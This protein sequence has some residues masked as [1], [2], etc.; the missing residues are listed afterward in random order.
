MRKGLWALIGALVAIALLTPTAAAQSIEDKR[1]E[2]ERIADRLEALNLHYA[3][4]EED[5]AEASVRL[6]Q[7]TNEVAIAQ[8]Q[9]ADTE[10]ALGAVASEMNQVAIDSYVRAR[11]GDDVVQVL[12][13]GADTAAPL[14]SAYEQALLGGQ[15]VQGDALDS[16]LEDAATARL[17]LQVKQGEQAS[18]Q[19]DL[20]AKQVEVQAAAAETKALLDQVQGELAVLV[21][22]ERQRRAA[23]ERAAAQAA[24]E[25]AAAAQRAREN[26]P[27]APQAGGGSGGSSESGSGGEAESSAPPPPRR[28]PPPPSGG[29]A[30]AVES[31]LSQIGVPYRWATADP[32]V[33]FD[34][35]GLVS[36]AWGRNGRQ[37]PR[38][39][40]AMFNALPRVDLADIQP[41]DLVFFG[42]PVH[43]VGM[44][45]GD[46]TMVDAPQSGEVVRTASIYRRDMA[47][48]GRP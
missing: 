11:P 40:R 14:R 22:Q 9:V 21:E 25:R 39:S 3:V 35:S 8:Q 12:V 4:L 20:A 37:L 16:R 27:Q 1:R 5:Y 31:A 36:W 41:G 47:G 19:A 48:I 44:Y 43:H 24:A 10:A 6:E 26:A 17:Q 28:E 32:D 2:A 42:S 33:G 13:S 23:A 29:A 15:Q 46:G 7:V 34:C 18:I 30:G 38:S 45:I